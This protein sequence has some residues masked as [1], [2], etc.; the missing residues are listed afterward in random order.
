MHKRNN[1]ISFKGND[2]TFVST[3]EI[4]K[5]NINKDE[6]ND[7]ISA[8]REDNL[9]ASGYTSKVFKA[10]D[11]IIKVPADNAYLNIQE[12][13]LRNGQNLK[14]YYALS[15]IKDIDS[16]IAVNP[17]GVVKDKD[18]Y[19]LVEDLVKGFNPKGNR[20]SQSHV[21]NLLD[22]FLK[23]DING[24]TNCDLQSGNIFLTEDG[25]TKL[26]DF[27]SFNFI[28]NDGYVMSSDCITFELFKKHIYDFTSLEP[29]VRFLKTF[30]RNDFADGKN[31]A[32]NPYLKIPSNATNFEFRTLYTHLLDNSE[33]NSLEFFKEYLKSKAQ[34]YH[35][36]L[37]V[38]LQSLSF[39]K[40]DANSEPDKISIAKNELQNAI[41]Y[42][43]LI[44]KALAECSDDVLKVELSKM[45]L[46]AFMNLGDSLKSP[47][48]NSKKLQAAYNQLIS[49]LE[50][51]IKNTQGYKKEYFIQ[52][53]NGFKNIF[54][55][56][57]FEIGQVDIPENE[58][59]IKLLFEKSVQET[60]QTTQLPPKNIIGT[61]NVKN[62]S[63]NITNKKFIPIVAAI[64]ATALITFGFIFKNNKALK[65]YMTTGRN[66][67]A[68]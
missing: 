25:R 13:Q 43:N 65:E 26:I 47:V 8:I 20:L 62:I 66:F 51:A 48:E 15:T 6:I 41:N 5:G 58:N 12:Q 31:L 17:Y 29:S 50:S 54:Q 39:D 9:M 27:G 68:S 40:I 67:R 49:N 33:E 57:N 16:S 3:P 63:K 44:E 42:E 1:Y 55:N 28:S 18:K 32:D 2:D 61:Q 10:G 19:Y 30:L 14:E 60:K 52:T 4:V 37:K 11:K 7:L 36:K 23:L 53:L 22:K 38:F 64:S 46:R 59:L 56:Y 35:T 34:N 24:I 45:Q 21:E